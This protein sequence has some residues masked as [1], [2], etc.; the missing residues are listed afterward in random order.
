MVCQDGSYKSYSKLIDV[1]S[2]SFDFQLLGI[3]RAP[4]F[5]RLPAPGEEVLLSVLPS[6]TVTAHTLDIYY[7]M[8]I[9]GTLCFVE[10]DILND[11]NIF[12]E[13]LTETAPTIL[14]GN[15]AIYERIY[16]R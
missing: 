7:T 1:L 12:F 15:P 3:M 2:C 6:S 14:F 16:T 11:T 9:A 8:S 10:E 13:A 5:N 4:G